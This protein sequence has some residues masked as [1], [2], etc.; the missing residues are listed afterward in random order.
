MPTFTEDITW[1]KTHLLL[2]IIVV[3]LAFGSLYG[4]ES[5]IAKHDTANSDQWKAILQAQTIQTQSIADKLAADEKTWAQQTAAQQAIIS[6]LA[7]SIVQR[8]NVLAGR[9]KQDSTLSAT[10]AAQR[11]SQ[12]TAAQPGEVTA[13]GDTVQ[14]DLSVSRTVTT[15]LDRLPVVQADLTDTQKQLS[16]QTVITTVLQSDIDDKQKLI[17][18]MKTEAVDADKSCKAEI[19]SVKA[20]ARKSKLKWFG[21]GFLIG[22]VSAHFIGI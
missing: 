15:D 20:S 21:I 18:A 13:Q 1:L 9:I 2:L 5:I 12:L 10:E 16:A 19:T 22:L 14:L 3:L 11:I 6:Q 7:S 8:N 17:D 4:I